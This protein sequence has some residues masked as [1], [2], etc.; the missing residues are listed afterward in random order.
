MADDSSAVDRRHRAASDALAG[1]EAE[2]WSTSAR[3]FAGKPVIVRDVS[4]IEVK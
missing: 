2:L 1:A 4:V 3:G